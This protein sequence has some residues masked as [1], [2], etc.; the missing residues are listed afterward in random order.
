MTVCLFSI[1]IPIYKAEKYLDKCIKSVLEQDFKDYELIL[2]DDGSPDKCPDICD[3][4]SQ[5]D[6]RVIVVHKENGGSVSARKAG[7][8]KAKGDY[9]VFLDSDDWFEKELLADLEKVISKNRPSTI[10]Y[11][12]KLFL[13]DKL[14]VC[15]QN[16][17]EGMYIDNKRKIIYD[18]MMSKRPFF[19]FGIYPTLWTTCSKREI[20]LDVQKDV[21]NEIT[22]G[23]DASIVYACLLKSNSIIVSKITGCVYRDNDQSMT[24]TFDKSMDERITAL[25]NYI[26]S[27]MQSLHLENMYQ[28]NDYLTFMTIQVAGNYL[29]NSKT[30]YK[31]K[32][33]VKKVRSFLN[34]RIISDALAACDVSDQT[35]PFSTKVKIVLLRKRWLGLYTILA[36]VFSALNHRRG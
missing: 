9:I 25:A 4:Y 22:L 5:I 27:S 24:H 19:A 32:D 7:V 28:V 16:S 36:K 18:S 13:N 20:L 3:Y 12:Y 8:E 35:C 6:S 10:V 17:E 2:V 29:L 14:S 26:T 1:V 23:D 30:E 31:R 33:A 15:Y 21:P 11:G 34:Q